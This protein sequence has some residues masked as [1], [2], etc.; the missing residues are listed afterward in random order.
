MSFSAD[1]L[2]LMECTNNHWGV[3]GFTRDYGSTLEVVSGGDGGA[4][5]GIIGVSKGLMPLYDGLC[6][7]RWM[8]SLPL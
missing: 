2:N 1:E 3:C 7:R 4:A 6:H 5:D 8:G